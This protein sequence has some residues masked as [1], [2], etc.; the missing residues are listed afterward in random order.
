MTLKLTKTSKIQ[1]LHISRAPSHVAW[2]TGGQHACHAP[3]WCRLMQVG[4]C[5][6]CDRQVT[7]QAPRGKITPTPP[8]NSAAV[9][10]LYRS[11]Y[12]PVK[13]INVSSLTDHIQCNRRLGLDDPA[14]ANCHLQLSQRVVGLDGK[15][16]KFLHQWRH[17]LLMLTAF[18]SAVL[19][20]LISWHRLWCQQLMQ[21]YRPAYTSTSTP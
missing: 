17:M 8:L 18:F 16:S 6:W 14:T 15:C 12:L 7:K 13:V 4:Y 20:F 5:L 9:N 11:P 10:S 21:I 1:D 2:L 19:I 3:L